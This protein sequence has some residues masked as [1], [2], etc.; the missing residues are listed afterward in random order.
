MKK[1]IINLSLVCALALPFSSCLKDLNQ[2]PLT[3]ITSANLYEDF[4]NYKGV[5]AKCY[6]GFATTGNQGPAG[7]ADIQEVDEGA[8]SYI[9][10]LWCLQELPT[11]AAK[12]QWGDPDL[13]V[14]NTGDWSSANGFNKAM[15]YRIFFQISLC[16]EFLRELTDEKL[17]SRKI[18]GENLID[19]KK[20]RAE[21]R[22][23]RALSYT[24]ALDIYGG[25][26]P[27]VT[28]TSN[29]SE[30]P[31][32]TTSNELF[33]YIES[34]CKA[35]E[36]EMEIPGSVEYGRADRAAAWM[37][38]SRLYLNAKVYT[39]SERYAD[40]SV[41]SKKVIDV[42]KYKLDNKYADLFKAD[43]HTS[44]EIIFSINFDGV[45]TRTYGGTTFLVH[46]CVGGKMN[47]TD[48]GIGGGWGGMRTTPEF[49]D[50]FSNE[51]DMRGMLFKDGQTK[52]MNKLTGSFED[53]WGLAKFSNKKKNGDAGADGL[54]VDT[55]FPMFRLGE[56]YLNYAEANIM[57]G[58]GDANL[59]LQYI[60][61]IRNR[62]FAGNVIGEYT[63]IADITPNELIDERGRELYHECLRRT[64]LR[65]FNKFAGDGVDYKWSWKGGVQSGTNLPAY[66]AIYPIPSSD[67]NANNNLKQNSGY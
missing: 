65:R 21:V 62:A 9:R 66:K 7:K 52:E 64:D 56:A 49:A 17:A 26:V 3:D 36:N 24:H 4:K 67:L 28:E 10:L 45:R 20:Y 50:K 55:D 13:P 58:A 29:V 18:E 40:A 8:S 46:A 47:P 1:L 32:Q 27:F 42:T 2:K 14:L 51:L 22:F 12:C 41:Y 25:N 38:L 11:D 33:S 53:G 19:A 61:K 59:A 6:A 5:L 48:Y 63:S 39:G 35:I 31:K 43:N 15:Y 54:F 60:N 44:E 57:G 37:L 30:L 16:N 23:L 34:E